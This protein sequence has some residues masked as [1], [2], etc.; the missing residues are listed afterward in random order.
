MFYSVPVCVRMLC[1]TKQCGDQHAVSFPGDDW[2]LRLC[3][4]VVVRSCHDDSDVNSPVVLPQRSWCDWVSTHTHTRFYW[5]KQMGVVSS[6][7]MSP[8]GFTVTSY[9]HTHTSLTNHRYDFISALSSAQISRGR[10]HLCKKKKK[11]DTQWRRV[12]NI[13][14]YASLLGYVT[15]NP[16]DPDRLSPGH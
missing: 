16:A 12:R 14:I 15:F 5:W 11:Q 6:R 9:T 7:L 4:C 1:Q 10:S 2:W 3:V 8:L 13:K